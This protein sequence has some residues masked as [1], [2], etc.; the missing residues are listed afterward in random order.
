MIR[1]VL[2]EKSDTLDVPIFFQIYRIVVF[3]LNPFSVIVARITQLS[4]VVFILFV[5]I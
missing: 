4:I 2:F 1:P 5:M 3:F